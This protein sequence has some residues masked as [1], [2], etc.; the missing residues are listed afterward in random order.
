MNLYVD[1]KGQEWYSKLQLQYTYFPNVASM[2]ISCRY[3]SIATEL[4]D[5]KEK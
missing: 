5:Y 2:L 1:E 3:K 4:S